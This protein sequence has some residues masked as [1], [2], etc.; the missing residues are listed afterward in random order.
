MI[1]SYTRITV[2]GISKIIP[3][4]SIGVIGLLTFLISPD[5][6]LMH[7][8]MLSKEFRLNMG[9][10]REIFSTIVYAFFP[11]KKATKPATSKIAPIKGGQL[12]EWLFSLLI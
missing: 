8:I 1:H 11:V 6:Y 5:K 9:L 10:Q 3:V 2:I 12:T 4:A 7:R